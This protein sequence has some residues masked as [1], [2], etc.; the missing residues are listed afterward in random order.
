MI[1]NLFK[2][3]IHLTLIY[4]MIAVPTQQS[5]LA[6][7]NGEGGSDDEEKGG[8]GTSA[9]STFQSK[10]EASSSG[11][12]SPIL[13]RKQRRKEKQPMSAGAGRLMEEEEVVDRRR[14]SDI[15]EGRPR[16]KLIPKLDAQRL[17]ALR[18]YFD[19][20]RY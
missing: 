16:L 1:L 11:E 3:F 6:M 15:E 9:S 19:G 7:W 10:K 13:K 2:K 12:D 18:G 17:N 4:C 5:A 14:D 20:T 8:R